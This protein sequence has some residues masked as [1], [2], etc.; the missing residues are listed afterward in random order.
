MPAFNRSATIARAVRSIRAQSLQ[1]WELR[2]GDD[3]ST[4]DTAEAAIMAAEEDPRIQVEKLPENRGAAAA[5][6]HAWRQSQSAFVAILDSDDVALPHRLQ[7][8][9]SYFAE[10]PEVAVIGGAAHFV[11]QDLRYLRTVRLP[12]RHEHLARRRWY[13]C[14][15]VHPTVMMRRSFLEI[16][17]GYTAGL[18]LGEDY[19]LW[20]RGFE[21]DRF[22]YHNLREPLVIYRTRPVQR[23][24]MIQASARVRVRAGRREGRRWRANWAACRILAEGLI[25]QTGIFAWRDRR[26]GAATPS[27]VQQ[28]VNRTQ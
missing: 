13:A 15:F 20:M 18:R 24:T 10:H 16:T 25:E 9:L 22:R 27:E 4:D 3:G 8:Q 23:W 6:N 2:G 1:E 11:D 19:D 17:G 7:R 26:R 21:L 12:E 28:A 14:P 5:M